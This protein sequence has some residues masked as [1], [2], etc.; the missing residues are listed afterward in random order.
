MRVNQTHRDI[1]TQNTDLSSVEY[2]SVDDLNKLPFSKQ[3]NVDYIA[4]FD[5]SVDFNGGE[6]AYSAEGMRRDISFIILLIFDDSCRKTCWLTL[7]DF[8]FCLIILYDF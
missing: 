1:S 2:D 6:A 4:D 3:P 5:D 7:A 8:F